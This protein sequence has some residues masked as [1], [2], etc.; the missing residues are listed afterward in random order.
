M[1]YNHR[2]RGRTKFALVAS[3]NYRIS[4]FDLTS[5]DGTGD[6]LTEVFLPACRAR[7]DALIVDE[8]NLERR[9]KIM[10]FSS[11]GFQRATNTPFLN[12]LGVRAAESI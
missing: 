2:Y 3:V 11:G 9:Y 6:T 1:R 5:L 10:N 7:V 4:S 8:S 12:Q